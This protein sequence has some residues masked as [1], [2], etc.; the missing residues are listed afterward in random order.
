[1]EG[2]IEASPKDVMR[3]LTD[4]RYKNSWDPSY[5]DYEV[6]ETIGDQVQIQYHQINRFLILSQRDLLIVTMVKLAE[7]GTYYMSYYS[8]DRN[9][10]KPK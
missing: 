6:I 1:M 3:V 2:F 5:K 8:I 10:I 9:D 4:N 7:D